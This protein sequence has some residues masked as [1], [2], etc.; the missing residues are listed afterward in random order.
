MPSVF[1]TLTRDA[2]GARDRALARGR[3]PGRG[4]RP[5]VPLPAARRRALPRRPPADAR[6]TSATRSSA[7]SQSDGERRWLF[8]P[9]RGAQ[10]L[11]D[12]RG[13][14]TSR[15]SASTRPSEFT[16]ELE[17]PV[18]FFPALLSLP[19]GGDRARGQRPRR[20]RPGGWVGHGA[21]P[22]RRVRARAGGSSWS[23]TALLARR[24]TR[25]ARGSSSRFGVSPEEILAGLPR[26]PVLARLGPLP[27]RR[28]G[29]A[30][31]ARVRAPATARRPRLIDLLRRLQ[32]P[33]RA[34]RRPRRC[35]SG[36]RSAVDVRGSSARR[37]A[38]WRSR[39][40][41]HPAGP[42]RPRRRRP[43]PRRL[44]RAAPRSA[45]R[46]PIELTR[47]R[48]PGVLREVRGA[49]ARELASGVRASRACGSGIVNKTMD[50][51]VEATRRARSDLA[52]GRWG[53]DYPD[54]DTFVYILH[55]REGFLGRLLR[56][57]RDRPARRAG[58]APRRA[59]RAS[60]ALPPGRGDDRARGAAAS[61]L[62]RAGLPLRPARGRGPPGL[63]RHR[64]PSPTRS[65]T[66]A[67]DLR[68][69]AQGVRVPCLHV[70]PF[71]FR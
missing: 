40:R 60:R 44:R 16:I 45:S 26:R 55:S 27:G 47:G 68:P 14:A 58:G 28:R 13:R 34:P 4:G 51:F 10:A 8:S 66:C 31:R 6:A 17:E 63:V 35:A 38:G 11:L 56:L 69:P 42:A 3:V 67:A 7:C 61:A 65:C 53:A 33:P 49:V 52:V 46:P 24:A 12:G 20:A 15:A 25:A 22:R 29:A 23:A 54:A 30:A 70:A 39:P 37:W 32:H 62:P 71:I 21:V 50:E 48:P 5:A 19:V 1:E 57:P 18:A 36:S 9:I 64:R 2:G 41:P 43:R 59:R